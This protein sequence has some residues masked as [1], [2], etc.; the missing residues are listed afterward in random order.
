MPI[1]IISG[2]TTLREAFAAGKTSPSDLDRLAAL[3][4]LTWQRQTQPFRL[5]A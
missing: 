5:Y 1:D 2:G 3:D 4:E